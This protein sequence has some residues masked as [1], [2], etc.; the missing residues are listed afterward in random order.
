MPVQVAFPFAS[1][2]FS[3]QREFKNYLGEITSTETVYGITSLTAK[4]A[5]PDRIL[6]LNRGHWVIENKSHYVRDVTMGE[7]Q[8]QIRKENG[9]QNM[10]IIRNLSLNIL[11]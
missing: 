9:P 7:D 6:A 10:A 4:Q 2:I 8:S 3:I 5:G 1:Q 11:I